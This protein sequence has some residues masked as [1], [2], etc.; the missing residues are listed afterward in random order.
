MYNFIH[1]PWFVNSYYCFLFMYYKH[2]FL[3]HCKQYKIYKDHFL[4]C[5][6][7]MCHIKK[8]MNYIYGF[9]DGSLH[10][11]LSSTSRHNQSVL[12]V[13]VLFSGVFCLFVAVFLGDPCFFYFINCTVYFDVNSLEK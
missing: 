6:S 4:L 2:V 9:L 7:R 8:F 10:F 5:I 11:P 12:S 13:S 1:K 3:W